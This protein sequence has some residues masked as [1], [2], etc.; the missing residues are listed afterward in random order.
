MITQRE[1]K[2]KYLKALLDKNAA[3]FAGAGLSVESG[4][5]NWKQLLKD[6]AE[7]IGLDIEKE[8]DLIAV[9]QYHKN[10]R[11]S[12]ATINQEI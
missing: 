4:L 5:V 12:R 10:E 1:F 11:K 9:A 8:T 7:D 6:I 2:K 3:V